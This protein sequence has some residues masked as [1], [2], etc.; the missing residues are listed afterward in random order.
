MKKLAISLLFLLFGVAQAATTAQTTAKIETARWMSYALGY[1]LTGDYLTYWRYGRGSAQKVP[2]W[3]TTNS[4]VKSHLQVHL[5][6]IAA[7]ARRDYSNGKYR[8]GGRYMI[9]RVS[10]IPRPWSLTDYTFAIGGCTLT[11]YADVYFYKASNGKIACQITSWRSMLNDVYR[12]D[13]SDR[14]SLPAVTGGFPPRLVQVGFEYD[15]LAAYA[16]NR[17]AYDFNVYSDTIPYVLGWF[18][19]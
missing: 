8:I 2:Q 13:S 17:N 6:D 11:T 14:Y 18:Y 5:N 12:F 19:L 15:E 3:V 7:A 10:S 16:R 9:P 1:N 4:N